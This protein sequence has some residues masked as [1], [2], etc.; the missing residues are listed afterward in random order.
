M[1]DKEVYERIARLEQLVEDHVKLDEQ[2]AEKLDEITSKQDQIISDLNRYRGWL[3]G[4]LAVISLIGLG[5]KMFG[6]SIKSAI[7]AMFL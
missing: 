6:A 3:G 1:S 2:R 4:V 7:V 5:I